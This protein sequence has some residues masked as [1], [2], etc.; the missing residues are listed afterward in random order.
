[1]KPLEDRCAIHISTTFLPGLGLSHPSDLTTNGLPRCYTA[2]T[3][4]T[5]TGF[6]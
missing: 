3:E 1:M 6:V 5:E 2:V 4:M